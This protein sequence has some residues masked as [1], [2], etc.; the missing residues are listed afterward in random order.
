MNRI[1]IV[2]DEAPIRSL[3]SQTLAA[4]GYECRTAAD[5]G[6]ARKVLA[7]DEVDLLLSDINMPGESGLDLVRHALSESPELAVIMV[8]AIDDHI[9]ANSMLEAG[10]F[11]YIAKPIDRNRV[12]ISVANACRRKSLEM[13]NRQYRE[14]LEQKVAEQTESL[15]QTLTQLRNAFDG[16]TQAIVHIVET[17]D[18]YTAGHQKRVARLAGAI[19]TEMS[20]PRKTID[21]VINAGNIHDLGKISVPS[22]VLSKPGRLTSIEFELIKTHSAVGHEILKDID[23]PW[24]IADIIHQHHE[25]I[26]GSGYPQGISGDDILIEAR[27]LTVA[28]VLEAM[29]S[30]R[31]YRPA[32]GIDIA[33]DELMKNRG[34]LYE[35]AAVDACVSLL[36]DKGYDLDDLG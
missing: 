6:E 8:T 21:G 4:V 11:D 29:A 2:D 18:P 23:F 27:I 32:L 9:V 3:L 33:I 36:Q 24:P 31:P 5:A 35:P 13:S 26:D 30:H 14:S 22:E 17:R 10:V 12:L 7:A 19:A 28:D 34:S 15:Q 1:L 20:C 25:K 16:I